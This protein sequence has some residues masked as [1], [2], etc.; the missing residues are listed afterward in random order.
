LTTEPVFLDDD[1]SSDTSE[2]DEADHGEEKPA[3]EKALKSTELQYS[4]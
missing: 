4:F 1:G 2:D 3:A